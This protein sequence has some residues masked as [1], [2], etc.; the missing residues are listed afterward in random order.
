MYVLIVAGSIA[1]LRPLALLLFGNSS[2][3]FGRSNERKGYRN[4]SHEMDSKRPT[5]NNTANQ[6]SVFSTAPAPRNAHDKRTFDEADSARGI[7]DLEPGD[8]RKTTEVMVD[9]DTSSG[10]A[11]KDVLRKDWGD[12]R[13]SDKTIEESERV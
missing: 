10:Y 6:T 11:P 3:L 7:L 5:K 4:Q 9:Y 2:S 12:D 13:E 8:I 1:T